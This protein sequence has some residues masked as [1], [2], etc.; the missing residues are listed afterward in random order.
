MLMK[1]NTI[2]SP[3]SL[4]QRE[5]LWEVR[6]NKICTRFTIK[7]VKTNK[8]VKLLILTELVGGVAMIVWGILKNIQ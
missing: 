7:K 2:S 4:A 6:S 5:I 3:D 8:S 1:S